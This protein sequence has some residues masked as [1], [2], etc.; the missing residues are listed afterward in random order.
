MQGI[1][2]KEIKFPLLSL[3]TLH[4]ENLNSL[5]DIKP[6]HTSYAISKRYWEVIFMK[7]LKANKIVIQFMRTNNFPIVII[8]L[9]K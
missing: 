6:I 7:I 8:Y 9:M 2:V 5:I 3:L 1:T 4:S